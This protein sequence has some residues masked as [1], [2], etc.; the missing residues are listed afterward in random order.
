MTQGANLDLFRAGPNAMVIVN[1]T[2]TIVDAN[3]PARA[4]FLRDDLIGL[5]VDELVPVSVRHGHHAN[6]DSFFSDPRPRPMGQ[7]RELSA[8]RGDGS[9][10]PV[11]ISLCPVPGPDGPAV[12][13]TVVDI[14]LLRSREREIRDFTVNLEGLIEEKTRKLQEAN[15][16]L[17]TFISTISHDL[18]APLR[19]LSGFS[20]A[21]R[22]DF[23]ARL[24]AEGH[25]YLDQIDVSAR[26]LADLI[27]GLLTLSRISE[28]RLAP[29][30]TDVTRFIR[31]WASQHSGETSPPTRWRIEEGLTCVADPYLLQVLVGNLLDNAWKYSSKTEAR[32]IEAFATTDH[33]GRWIA[34]RDNGAGFDMAYQQL[35]FRPFQ[36]LHRQD[37]FP[38]LGIG[39]ATCARIVA[40]MDGALRAEGAVDQG[41]TVRFRF[42]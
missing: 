8:R 26:H 27:E 9:E 12:V 24:P 42:P 29:V 39:L 25:F 2:G 36:R 6:R 32:V 34:I 15:R 20:R 16:E 38:G 4:L 19:G 31:E 21:L 11:E 3:E 41:A 14:S 17:E 7:G 35:L 37:E 18:K 10:F 33:E 23:G 22:E 1:R 5:A 30:E 40:R 13:A 28:R